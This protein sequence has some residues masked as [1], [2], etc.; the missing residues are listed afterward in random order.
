M[1][2]KSPIALI[3]PTVHARA[4]LFE[5]TLGYLAECECPAPV[6]VSDH[7][8]AGAQDVISGIARRHG[9]LDIRLL[10][11][12]PELHF[13]KR[14]VA[15]AEV[16]DTPYVHL[17]ADDDFI[18]PTAVGPLI[19]VMEQNPDCSAV[20]GINVHLG[21]S[22]SVGG[23]GEILHADPFER[24]IA[25][26][27]GYSSV[28]YALRRTGEFIESLSFA[29]D[30]CPDV[31]FWQYLESC[32]AALRGRICVIDELHYLRSVHPG[33]WSAT[34]VRERSRDHFPYL[35]LSPEF[36]PRFSAFREALAEACGGM[37]VVIDQD[38]LDVGLIHLL[39]HGVAAMGLPK[40]RHGRDAW[41]KRR[42]AHDRVLRERLADPADS[43]QAVMQ[44]IL[45]V[46]GRGAAGGT[47]NPG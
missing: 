36:Q 12:P 9:S 29:A 14:L 22:V 1:S 11:H 34:L 8:P 20:M 42:D 27:E 10:R 30:R 37:G 25:Q 32:V 3:I 5:R 19:G 15:C 45:R 6:V 23:R 4:A 46:L 7:S 16:A 43:A 38:A 39:N 13:L 18:A 24:L 2:G 26:L 41:M 33:K 44:H 28:L 35:I 40:A 47:G 21:K 17:H 31:Q